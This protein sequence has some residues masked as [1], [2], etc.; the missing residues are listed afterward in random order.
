MTLT[1]ITSAKQFGI[2][3]TI[4][5]CDLC[6]CYVI[7]RLSKDTVGNW[8]ALTYKIAAKQIT[9]TDVLT[10]VRLCYLVF[11]TIQDHK[12]KGHINLHK[13]TADLDFTWLCYANIISAPFEWY[14][15]WLGGQWGTLKILSKLSVCTC[16]G[17]TCTDKNSMKFLPKIF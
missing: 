16:I 10:N 5:M 17:H 4:T 12:R 15:T 3:Y 6:T 1:L 13:D 7:P 8:M 14:L 2:A 11:K 9:S